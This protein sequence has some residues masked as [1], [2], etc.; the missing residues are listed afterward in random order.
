MVFIVTSFEIATK[1]LFIRSY[2]KWFFDLEDWQDSSEQDRIDYIVGVIKKI[3]HPDLTS[4]LI[5][6]IN[7]F[8]K[9][10]YRKVN[11]EEIVDFLMNEIFIKNF[12]KYEYKI[13]FNR[14]K[15][16]GSFP[17]LYNNFLNID[18]IKKFQKKGDKWTVFRNF[19]I[20]R[21]RII[22]NYSVS[23]EKGYVENGEE[24]AGEIVKFLHVGI[25]LFLKNNFES[26]RK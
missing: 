23:V 21:H 4:S 13:N 25:N 3:G 5:S 1:E 11:R 10:N 7:N 26:F 8:K 20:K 18:V 9:N 24:I 12:R 17:W 14:M 2:K 6:F 19:V 22:H 16:K 15:D